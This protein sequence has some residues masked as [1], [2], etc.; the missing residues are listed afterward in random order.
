MKRHLAVGILLVAVQA[1]ADTLADVRA[2]V[3]RLRAT[4]PVKA[5]YTLQQ[6]VLAKGKFA[7]RNTQRTSSVEITHDATGL[8]FNLAKPMLDDLSRE[9]R[10]RKGGEQP[11][12]DA[13][14]SIRTLSVLEAIDFRD[15][16]LDIL[17]NSVVTEEKRVAWHG[18]Q[19]RLLV[20]KVSEPP[21]DRNG[22]TTITIGS[23]S[24][25]DRMNLWI[26][27]DDLPLAA[28]RVQETTA[29]I[30]FING[31][32]K[33]TSAY[34]FGYSADRIFIA[35]LESKDDGSGMG[36]HVARN[37]VQTVALR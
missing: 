26:G 28:N 4:T 19:V 27:D 13:I 6:V 23:S 11:A 14:G 5:V 32:M 15:A 21:R 30:L 2:A 17:E 35:R 8:T 31:T 9:A 1:E 10:S 12:R 37:A 24:T 7:N 20:L 3:A 18:R 22:G 16:L 29:G 33:G 34:T 36:Q 25:K